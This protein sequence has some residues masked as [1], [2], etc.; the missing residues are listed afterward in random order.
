MDSCNGQHPLGANSI[1]MVSDADGEQLL[2]IARYSI[3]PTPPIRFYG[4]LQLTPRP[5]PALN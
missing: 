3:Y 2:S 5:A 4:E 1:T